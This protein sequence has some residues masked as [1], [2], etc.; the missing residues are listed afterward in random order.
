MVGEWAS[1][2]CCHELGRLP[3]A[4]RHYR[5]AI[6]TAERWGFTGHA[7]LARA[8]LAVSLV[9]CGST[10]TARV[11]IDAAV[12]GAP[13]TVAPIVALLHGLVLQRTGALTEALTVYA[14]ALPALRQGG[15]TGWVARLLVNRG[16]LLAYRGDV[17]TATDDLREAEVLA[18]QLGL[19]VLVAMAAHNLAF[20]ESRSG[21]PIEA[22]R[23]FDRA[24]A[25][26]DALG[27]PPRLVAVLEG[28][29]C[30][31]LLTVGL[32]AEARRAAAAAI[33][34]LD[35]AGA[36]A[37]LAEAR[38]L[39]AQACL[40]DGQ[41]L[42]AIEE[43]GAAAAMLRAAGRPAWAALAEHVEL[44]ADV[45][46][47]A[48]RAG[49]RPPAGLL[50]RARA[51]AGALAA[52]GWP[53]EALQARIFV[54]QIALALGRREVARREL[55]GAE[56]AKQ[57]PVRLRV[58]ACLAVA[59]LRLADGDEPGAMDALAAGMALVDE[60]R[61]AL[62]ATE[63]RT[64][65][66]GV[67]TD[68]AR[69][70]TRLA[71]RQG[72]PTAVFAWS[73]R[74]RA[75]ALRSDPV[76]PPDDPGQAAD[77]ARLRRLVGQEREA[78]FNGEDAAA[79]REEMA[80]TERLIR[81]RTLRS[82][83]GSP[84]DHTVSRTADLAELQH[85]LGSRIL[86][87]LAEVDGRLLAVVVDGQN[88]VLR[89]LG[90]SDPVE[91]EQRHLLSALRRLATAVA[92]SSRAERARRAVDA[93]AT[94]LERLLIRP[95]RLP[96]RADLV[97]VPTGRLHG[98][99]WA[100]LSALRAGSV[101][102]TPSASMW[103]RP[104]PR[105]PARPRITL[106]AGPDLPGADAEVRQLHAFYG[107]ATLLVGRDATTAS[108]LAAFSEA[109]LLHVAAHGHFRADSPLFSRLALADGPLTIYDVERV[110]CRAATV[111]LPA[112]DAAVTEVLAGDEVL[113]TAAALL[114][115]GVHTVIAPILP[116]PD[117]A[118]GALMVEV[119][120]HLRARRPPAAAL[121]AAVRDSFASLDPQRVAAAAAFVCIG[122]DRG[123]ATA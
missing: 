105:R 96:A 76:R 32:T 64:R 99:P 79:V 86:V 51:V 38:L 11:E 91:A 7:A 42:L 1:G 21:R 74:A 120:R 102:L 36:V 118:S 48:G 31:V 92:D 53:V 34:A 25:A 4:I 115:N 50:A 101:E 45:R 61:A 88:V 24:E 81:D 20:A 98:V 100:A 82:L 108:V 77:L 90:S 14:R 43:A 83:A 40:A 9:S 39:H 33:D 70:A 104:P 93:A 54:A 15:E 27:R 37:D 5:L 60:H 44:Q 122:S 3:A 112:C 49:G 6:R 41:L 56:E 28:D 123:V 80:A 97:V 94:E 84:L 114:A 65:A 46:S 58:Q 26:Y 109:D 89:R 52:S 19:V 69:V 106:V 121:A 87:E 18:R 68:L 107:R 117:L 72:S 17:A 8:S 63:L 67:G 116:I 22:L 71:A 59:L 30:E 78:S 119:H 2:L 73:E 113:G 103:L 62:G 111:L 16:V 75:N 23:A 66:A 10:D 57:G 85:R 110:R 35:R 13:E 95:L 55:A 12:A 29:R 47:L